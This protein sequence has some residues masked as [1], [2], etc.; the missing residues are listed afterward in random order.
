LFCC[1][2]FLFRLVVYPS[3]LLIAQY[4]LSLAWTI[5]C[6]VEKAK[7]EVER[8]YGQAL[9]A[10]Q[11]R[12]QSLLLSVTSQATTFQQ[13]VQTKVEALKKQREALSTALDKI[14]EGMS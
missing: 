4:R 11:A 10:L 13:D 6:S 9:L 1:N 12:K 14:A 8:A 2:F 3:F 7:G 5:S